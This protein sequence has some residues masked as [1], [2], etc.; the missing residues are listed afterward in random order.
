M[1]DRLLGRAELKER[2]AEL[3]AERDELA[4]RLDA[5]SRRR[6]DAVSDRQ[7]A[8]KR[9]NR[10]ED[11]IA[12]LEDRVDRT[13]TDGA[14]RGYRR[15]D[16][17]V[18]GQ[19]DEVLA[20][21]R[22]VETEPEGALTAM[23]EEPGDEVRAAVDDAAPLVARAAPALVLADDAGL[24]TVALVPPFPPEPFVAWGTGFRLDDD[25]FEPPDPVALA[26]VRSDLF[27]LGRYESGERV[28]VESFT[29]DVAENHS[30]GGFSQDRFERRR[31]EQVERHLSA[32]RE[33]L[34]D[35]DVPLVLAGER[36]VLDDLGVDAVSETA[37]DASGEPEAALDRA[38][39]DA[40][41][42]RLYVL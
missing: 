14:K 3:E 31:D 19:R 35:L 10:L 38:A 36:T 25:W 39:A 40:F 26:L 29:A 21:L 1:I 17:L 27:A 5:E 42:T 8:E 20:R 6:A 13:G 28:E 32:V 16:T 24:V 37:V 11:R 7:E 22:S 34:D 12:E 9:V 15:V 33:R 18:G 2:I 23:V 41:G 4:D 30:K